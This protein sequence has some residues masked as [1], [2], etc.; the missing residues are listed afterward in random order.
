MTKTTVVGLRR[1]SRQKANTSSVP[2]S[3]RVTHRLIKAFQ[4][5]GPARS[6]GEQAL[7]AFAKSFSMPLTPQQI[8]AVWSLTSLDSGPAMD[9][10]MS[11]S[12][13][14]S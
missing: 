2:V 6:I 14:R 3:K 7:E 11:G 9:A 10:C 13:R 1:S 8:A 5:V 12:S 4:V